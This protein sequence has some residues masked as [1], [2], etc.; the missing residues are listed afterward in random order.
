M[1]TRSNRGWSQLVDSETNTI[2][3][4]HNHKITKKRPKKTTSIA[5]SIAEIKLL[6]DNVSCASRKLKKF[7]TSQKKFVTDFIFRSWDDYENSDSNIQQHFLIEREESLKAVNQKPPLLTCS[8]KDLLLNGMTL[9]K[10]QH[11][12]LQTG[13]KIELKSVKKSFIFIDERIRDANLYP[14]EVTS[15]FYI[16]TTV[17]KGFNGEVRVAYN[18]KTLEKLAIKKVSKLEMNLMNEILIMQQFDHPN[19][20]KLMKV[21]DYPDHI[22]LLTEHMNAGDLMQLIDESPM[23]RL[24]EEDTKFAMYQILQGLKTLHQ[25]NV[26]HLDIK[27]E[28]IFAAH[29]NDDLVF[30]I[31]DFGQSNYDNKV[32]PKS[33][34]LWYQSPEIV[35]LKPGEFY[36]GKQSDMWSLGVVIYACL[37]GTF[38]FHNCFADILGDLKTQITDANFHFIG[39]NWENISK[40]ATEVI[41]CLL[42]VNAYDRWTSFEV[43]L[44]PW[45]D[46]DALKARIV[47]L[48][49]REELKVVARRRT[50]KNN[51]ET[52]VKKRM[53]II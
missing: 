40:D 2:G 31:G 4:I 32:H 20:L 42:Q 46:D 48:A 25:E 15:Q 49:P 14:P 8:G 39:N 36:N 21:F 41:E 19:L 30:K 53:T 47:K 23:R 24:S 10:H 51:E 12:I 17:G 34:T 27:I 6:Y 44:H 7:G 35:N 3:K 22:Y 9:K 50:M 11:H 18:L 26:A 16:G 45:F 52:K 38:P 37:S 33:G 1:I 29:Q 28:N 13:D 5:L 43:L